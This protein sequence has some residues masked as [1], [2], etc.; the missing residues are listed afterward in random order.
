MSIDGLSVEGKAD[1][2]IES[3]K[4]PLIILAEND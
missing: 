3:P 1:I 4:V 2:Q